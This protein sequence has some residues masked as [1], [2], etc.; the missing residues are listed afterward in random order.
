MI[1]RPP[2]STLFPYTTLFRS[3]LKESHA[4]FISTRLPFRGQARHGCSLIKQLQPQRIHRVVGIGAAT[5]PPILLLL[6]IA[7]EVAVLPLA[8]KQPPNPRVRGICDIKAGI[9]RDDQR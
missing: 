6:A 8:R 2:R 5:R 9:M 1:R 3:Q 4:S 7:L